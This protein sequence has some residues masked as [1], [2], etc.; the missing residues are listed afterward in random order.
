M[1]ETPIIVDLVLGVLKRINNE[2]LKEQLPITA[3][4]VYPKMDQTYWVNLLG[5]GYPAPSTR[6]RWCTERMKIDP[7]NE[8]IT[9]R[10]AEFGEIILALGSRRQESNTRAQV[11]AKHKIKVHRAMEDTLPL[12]KCAYIHANRKLDSGRCMGIF[13]ECSPSPMGGEV[14]VIGI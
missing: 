5:R 2:A 1:V 6:F 4:S 9:D 3:H 14:I 7:V 10:V 12:P 11:M 8:F 13:N